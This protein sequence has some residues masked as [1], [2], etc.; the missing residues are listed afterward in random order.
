MDVLF[1]SQAY[2][3][4]GYKGKNPNSDANKLVASNPCISQ[5]KTLFQEIS[6]VELLP[7]QIATFQQKRETL[8]AIAN[9]YGGNATT[10]D[11]GTKPDREIFNP[12]I[13]IAAIIELNKMDGDIATLKTEKKS[14]SRYENMTDV[15][16]DARIEELASMIV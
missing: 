9:L 11:A 12:R 5:Y 6:Q 1:Y 14:N 15:E 7:K 2:R 10:P 13:A 3:S 4:A 8:W 16:I